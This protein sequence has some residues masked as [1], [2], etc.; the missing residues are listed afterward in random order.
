[1]KIFNK[2]ILISLFS[3][4]CIFFT[5]HFLGK[6]LSNE[7]NANRLEI[8][9]QELFGYYVNGRLYTDYLGPFVINGQWSYCVEPSIST[10]VGTEYTET[11]DLFTTGYILKGRTSLDW[12]QPYRDKNNDGSYGQTY[13]HVSHKEMTAFMVYVLDKMPI[14]QVEKFIRTIVNNNDWVHYFRFV[15][16][17]R[18][19][20]SNSFV[21]WL[22][23]QFLVW[24]TAT[25]QRIPG[26]ND[27]AQPG[28]N[29][30]GRIANY[31]WSQYQTLRD[32]MGATNGF[33]FLDPFAMQIALGDR[34]NI[35]ITARAINRLIAQGLERGLLKK[36]SGQSKVLE[37]PGSQTLVYL[38]ESIV[39]EDKPKD[40]HIRIRKTVA[41][42]REDKRLDRKPQFTLEGVKFGV[43]SDIQRQNK[44]G[45]LITNAQGVTNTLKLPIGR[46][47]AYELNVDG[48]PVTSD[49]QKVVADDRPMS[50]GRGENGLYYALFDLNSNDDAARY[51]ETNPKEQTFTNMPVTAKFTILKE[52]ANKNKLGATGSF[53][54]KGAEY[55]LYYDRFAT[56]PV[57]KANG[58]IVKAIIGD[59]DRA[60]VTD[61]HAMTYYVKETQAPVGNL[62]QPVYLLDH[63]IYEVDLS[64]GTPSGVS[65]DTSQFPTTQLVLGDNHLN[66]IVRSKEMLTSHID[67]PTF[68]KQDVLKGITTKDGWGDLKNAIYE[69]KF[70]E[71]GHRG[72]QSKLK[73][74][75]LYSTDENGR[76]DVKS[77]KFYV[78]NSSPQH[79]VMTEAF[80]QVDRG[81]TAQLFLYDREYR[82]VTAPQGFK[83][84]NQLLKEELTVDPQG[85][86][87]FVGDLVATEQPLML[88]LFK[89]QAIDN[90]WQGDE[91]LPIANAEFRLVN[92]TT[93]QSKILRSDDQGRISFP[94][95]AD[96]RY[97]LTESRAAQGY[98]TSGQI[99]TF[100]IGLINGT[101]GMKNFGRP[102]ASKK[103]SFT[104]E[105]DREGDV[106]IV[107]DNIPAPV[108]LQVV[109]S[110]EKGARL[111]GAKFT[112]THSPKNGG[113]NR[114]IYT[115]NQ[116]GEIE[117]P[118]LIVGDW[119][120]IEETE[121]PLGYK[122]PSVRKKIH[123]RA[124][125]IPAKDSYQLSYKLETLDKYNDANTRS[126]TSAV[127]KIRANSAGQEGISAQVTNKL[128][129]IN[130][131][132]VN[133][134]Y[135][136]LPA[137]GSTLGFVTLVSVLS[138]TIGIFGYSIIKKRI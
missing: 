23:L 43:Y 34:F 48:Q 118:Q 58:Q 36:V 121:A 138:L 126:L 130:I 80:N 11:D 83:L 65:R 135:K 93:G 120:S 64:K 6:S 50:S 55:T 84:S 136:K 26:K 4:L 40:V 134:T 114:Q 38:G 52:Q 125:T 53:S 102:D 69:V 68:T 78:I 29:Q 96:G 62:N 44:V 57:R 5:G 3:M 17:V 73:A 110:N 128:M 16:G 61:L 49:G 35:A 123:F 115:T 89:R 86:L 1:M 32:V 25:S 39:F 104:I 46:Y 10:S 22:F 82:E 20:D 109:K 131:S 15:Q 56:R 103:G 106:S 45:E 97:E 12:H 112:L 41:D 31:S 129:Q 37:S 100:E 7:V 13:P 101:H 54:L 9:N 30:D 70:Y 63:K 108:K 47:Y 107:Y 119:Y 87:K 14:D 92:K 133:N 95:L 98:Q 79:D 111:S 60:E 2:K 51:I 59:N 21:R 33:E 122:L 105:T 113:I 90:E 8:R 77:Q 18:R 42:F 99:V 66:P 137:T 71:I 81:E 28:A 127:Q 124:E 91:N 74:K 67:A 72:D 76:I 132:M 24:D 75:A 27:I 116:N 88:K 85:N 117:I 94:G 19:L